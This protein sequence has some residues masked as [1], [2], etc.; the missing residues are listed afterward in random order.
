[1]HAGAAVNW[2]AVVQTTFSTNLGGAR[3]E[4]QG[5]TV[6]RVM[7]KGAGGAKFVVRDEFQDVRGAQLK[8]AIKKSR[9]RSIILLQL[10]HLLGKELER[11]WGSDICRVFAS[12]VHELVVEGGH[13]LHGEASHDVLD[14]VWSDGD[15]VEVFHVVELLDDL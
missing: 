14:Q 1:M 6:G 9:I 10:V 2:D 15:V 4:G 11:G 5:T 13:H 8:V 12:E 7:C 3:V